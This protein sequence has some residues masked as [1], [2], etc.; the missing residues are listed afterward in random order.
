[1]FAL[2][3]LPT[4]DICAAELQNWGESEPAAFVTSTPTVDVSFGYSGSTGATEP[5]K[6]A[7][8]VPLPLIKSP[9]VITAIALKTHG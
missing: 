5:V 8:T 1:M 2:R 7:L 4:F 6:H 3:H 9:E